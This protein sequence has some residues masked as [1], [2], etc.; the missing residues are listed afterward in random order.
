VW[1]AIQ[2][3]PAYERDPPR[4]PPHCCHCRNRPTKDQLLPDLGH[5]QKQWTNACKNG[6]PQETACNFK[7]SADMIET[8]CL[9]LVAHRTGAG[10][11]YDGQAGVITSHRDA[12]AY[13]TK[14]Y[15][16]GYPME[17]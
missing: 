5:F 13:L 11:T 1:R 12:N 10:L 3:A 8:M 7:Y 17:G 9:G 16:P 15:R 6:R 4:V 2:T 14:P